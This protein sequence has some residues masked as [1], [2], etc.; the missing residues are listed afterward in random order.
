MSEFSK[1]DECKGN[2]FCHVNA[3]CTN[4]IGSH[5]CKCHP[6]Y[7]GNGRD[8]TGEFDRLP[9]GLRKVLR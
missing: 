1:I 9:L 4:I 3:S 6:G 7:T 2:H 8:C 5:V